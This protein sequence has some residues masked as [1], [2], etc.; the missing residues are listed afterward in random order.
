MA[1]C[2]DPVSLLDVDKERSR[3]GLNAP[4]YV[5]RLDTPPATWLGCPV[6]DD[7][8]N[9]TAYI[10][11]VNRKVGRR[12]SPP[13]GFSE[14][15]Q[16]LVRELARVGGQFHDLQASLREHQ[17]VIARSFHELSA[18]LI[19]I[20]SHAAYLAKNLE[21]PLA[22]TKCTNIQADAENLLHILTTIDVAGRERPPTLELTSLFARVINPLRFGLTELAKR[23]GYSQL[24]IA[25]DGLRSLP[26][27]WIDE[28]MMRQVFY[29]LIVNAIKYGPADGAPLKVQMT[30]TPDRH[31]YRIL[32]R[33]WGIGIDPGHEKKVFEQYHRLKAAAA[34]DPTGSGIGLF[35]VKRI[36]EQHDGTVAVTG[37]RNP[38]EF[39]IH[40][41]KD[42]KK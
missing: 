35:V 33:D 26:K 30:W 19:A 13:A 20:R 16:M 38:T 6:L 22:P 32:V 21:H 1:N 24:D 34:R 8:R 7:R 14:G 15:D 2:P 31:T 27:M 3:L 42:P 9:L 10:R 28:A 25:A 40:I 39:T 37:N 12:G 23:W 4:L 5:E 41:R 11:L 29:N 18:P 17:E 36:L